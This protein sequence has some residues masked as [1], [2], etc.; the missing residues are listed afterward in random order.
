MPIALVETFVPDR[1]TTPWLGKFGLTLT[2]LV[3]LVGCT[4]IFSRALRTQQFLPSA[5]Q[6]VGAAAAVVALIVAA[7][8]VGRT[9]LLSIDRPAPNPWLVGAVAFV[10]SSLFF[11][12]RES[13]PW[14]A[15]GLLLIGAMLGLVRRWSRGAGWGTVHRLAL[16]G[17]ALL[18]YAWGGFQ[19]TV[20]LGRTG[21]IDLIG[22]VVFAFTAIALLAA[23]ISTVRRTGGPA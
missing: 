18:T 19:L 4:L 13:W 22:N 3:F 2:G 17:G 23:A 8:A 15:F 12:L 1:G 10:A 20:A 5:P 11:D 16:A 21:A 9:Y 14:V 6:M 7:F